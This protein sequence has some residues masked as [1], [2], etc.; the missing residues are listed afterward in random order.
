MRFAVVGTGRCGSTLLEQMLNLHPDLFV[1]RESHWIPKMFE[2][3]GLGRVP[4]EDLLRI[5]L[6][7]T[8]VT[9]ERV[10]PCDEA[11]L[12]LWFAD[13]PSEMTVAGAC[14][15]IGQMLARRDGKR[16]WADKTPDY[17]PY[18]VQLQTIWPSCQFVHMIRDG[19]AVAVSMSRHPGFRWLVSAGE[20]WWAP[21][22]FNGYH[23]MAAA[24][25]S[26]LAAYAALWE[27]R[28]SRI[29]DEASRVAPG[30]VLELRFEALVD[31][32][33]AVLRQICAFVDL[34]APD[35][36]LG[37]ASALV[38][39]RLITSRPSQDPIAELG[40]APR[41][42]PGGPRIRDARQRSLTPPSDAAH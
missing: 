38:D 34:P 22:S 19:R 21:V 28:L 29:R 14:D 10:L 1:M 32:P 5:V 42:T 7:T 18:L 11:T 16:V 23:R 25:D 3:A 12:R 33:G 6:A 2:H 37:S 8:F 4:V 35:G 13:G 9:G 31:D 39:P 15:R 30:T 36:W 26:P 24:Q 20:M 40:E 17:G 41:P 27:R